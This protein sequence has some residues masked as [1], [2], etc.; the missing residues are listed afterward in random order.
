[1]T[2]NNT[3]L[4]VTNFNFYGDELIALKD[5]TTGEI[6]TSINSVLRGIGFSNKDQI[7]KRRE[8]WINDV[9]ISKG[10]VKFNI[11]TQEVVAKND[12]TLFDEK[13]T[14]CIS[15]HKL[16][17][18]LAK[19]NIT[20][21]MKQNQSALASKLELYQDKCADVLA[22]VFLD[23]KTTDQITMQPILDTLNIFT[24]TVNG[25]LLL[26]NERMS[27][28]EESQEQVKKSLPKK[29][30]SY[31]SSKMFSKYQL[32]MD[33]FE[34]PT[35]KNGILYKELYKEFHNM[36]PDIE[37]NQVVDDYC[38]DNGLDSCFTLDAIEHDKTVRKLFES[39]V[40]GLLEKYDLI[41]E[42][43]TVREKTIFDD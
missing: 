26:L 15:Q 11:P 29:R 43:V 12:T 38:Y 19:I 41:S 36:Y 1:M 10:V 2:N 6:Y 22:S 27:K 13:D 40:D 42:N 21:K 35:G 16:P 8:K 5:N 39:L 20:P 3:A 14:Y 32:L 28:L 37:I 34:I 7:R 24:K 33:Y 4:Q 9:V 18:A 30:F 17:L 23:N 31:W 25:T